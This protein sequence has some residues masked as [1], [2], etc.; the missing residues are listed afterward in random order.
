M[1]STVPTAYTRGIQPP[2]GNRGD[3]TTSVAELLAA[4]RVL[5]RE[6][7]L[8]TALVSLAF[9]RRLG[10]RA[11]CRRPLR[12]GGA[13][14]LRNIRRAPGQRVEGSARLPTPLRRRA[15]PARP[16]HAGWS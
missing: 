7:T 5:Q 3:Y 2:D 6:L 12:R 10:A 9:G 14:R 4:Q 8:R 16:P 11:G 15:A 1:S 13:G